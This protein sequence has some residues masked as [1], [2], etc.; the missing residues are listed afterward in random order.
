MNIFSTQLAIQSIYLYICIY[1][2][3]NK[4]FLTGGES[5]DPIQNSN[6]FVP[7]F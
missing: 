2:F 5:Y 6:G 1:V 7:A 4:P 3:I